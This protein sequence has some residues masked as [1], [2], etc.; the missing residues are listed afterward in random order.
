MESSPHCSFPHTPAPASLPLGLLLAGDGGLG[1]HTAKL[2]DG[3]CNV[4]LSGARGRE[5]LGRCPRHCPESLVSQLTLSRQTVLLAGQGCSRWNPRQGGRLPEA[6]KAGP[7]QLDGGRG[8]T[9]PGTCVGFPSPGIAPVPCSPRLGH[10]PAWATVFIVI[11]LA[12][13]PP[14]PQEA[15]A[16]SQ[17]LDLAWFSQSGEGCEA[18]RK[19]LNFPRTFLL[20]M[21]L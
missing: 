18:S 15:A 8:V 14:V 7:G 17:S 13:A 21:F 10:R 1:A 16:L 12:A 6:D 9:R 3:T 4:G 5:A 11:L 19:K 2:P 20:R